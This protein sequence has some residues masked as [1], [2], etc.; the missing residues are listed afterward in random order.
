M[1]VM[2]NR[3]TYGTSVIEVIQFIRFDN[4]CLGLVMPDAIRLEKK[5]YDTYESTT[6]VEDSDFKRWAEQLCRTGYLDLTRTD[7][8]FIAT[9]GT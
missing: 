5:N 2:F 4:N 9:H 1:R 3:I 8:E 6:K 7:L